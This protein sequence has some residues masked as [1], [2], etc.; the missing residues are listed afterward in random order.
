MLI[1][2]SVIIHIYIP[3]CFF[4]NGSGNEI[5]VCYEGEKHVGADKG[6]SGSTCVFW[7]PLVNA[8]QYV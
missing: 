3:V 5:R 2:C 8:V 6:E 7:P 4:E 1:F